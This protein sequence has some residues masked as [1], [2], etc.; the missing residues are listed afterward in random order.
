MGYHRA[1]FD[2]TGVD[3][4]PQPHYP[5][6]FHQFNALSFLDTGLWALFDVVHASP[7][8]QGYSRMRHLP[9]LKDKAYPLLIDPVRA[10]LKVTGIPWVIENVED[11]P[12]ESEV[13]CGQ[14]FGLPMYR[15]RRFESNVLLMLPPHQTHRRVI[16]YGRGLGERGRVSSWER[17]TR[18]PD[19]MGC[20]WM[21][22]HEVG[23]AIPPAYT[24]FIGS[25]L[26]ACV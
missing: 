18:L 26:L 3:I 15:H 8:C 23:Q 5:F 2:V 13:F 22:Q 16:S 24:E 14:S 20:P 6:E 4:K 21:T 1:G 17:A 12:L 7:P 10:L 11:A 19:V 25:Q 9:W